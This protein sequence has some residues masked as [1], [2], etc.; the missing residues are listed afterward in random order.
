MSGDKLDERL[1]DLSD[2]IIDNI[3]AHPFM[4]DY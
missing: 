2:E 1:D 4:M 3:L